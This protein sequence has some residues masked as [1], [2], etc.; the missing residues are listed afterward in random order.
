MQ[1]A[2]CLG[3]SVVGTY[4][5]VRN[6]EPPKILNLRFVCDE[7]WKSDALDCW[8]RGVC[9]KCGKRQLWCRHSRL[10]WSMEYRWGTAAIECTLWTRSLSP[11][12]SDF[13]TQVGQAFKK[14]LSPL[15]RIDVMDHDDP[16]WSFWPNILFFLP[17]VSVEFWIC[18]VGRRVLNL[19]WVWDCFCPCRTVSAHNLKVTF[20]QRKHLQS[21]VTWRVYLTGVVKPFKLASNQ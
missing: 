16:R 17:N 11:A 5:N 8:W 13:E 20:L 9:S 14:V 15:G 21:P 10:K 2:F 3:K 7:G 4:T 6:H 19:L 1:E 18:K 12:T